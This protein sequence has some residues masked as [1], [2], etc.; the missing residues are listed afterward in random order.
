MQ[1]VHLG[2]ASFGNK[3]E[4]MGWEHCRQNTG[5]GLGSSICFLWGKRIESTF[6]ASR[7]L[8]LT[9]FTAAIKS[10]SARWVNQI[11]LPFIHIILNL[12]SNNNPNALS[13]RHS[14]ERCWSKH[15]A[16]HHWRP[17][18]CLPS[19][20]TVRLREGL[21]CVD[22][23]ERNTG[24]RRRRRLFDRRFKIHKKVSFKN[25]DVIINY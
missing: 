25:L 6:S 9:S 17:H 19:S 13:C 5:L 11:I 1:P 23:L 8:S 14:P 16:R 20:P 24:Y 18:Q 22:G 3:R 15:Q 4:K 21:A 12:P 10:V 7:L 2:G